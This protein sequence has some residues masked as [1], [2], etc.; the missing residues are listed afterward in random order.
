M[1]NCL[2]KID[3]NSHW[4]NPDAQAFYGVSEKASKEF[5]HV[6]TPFE[7][8]PL[9]S[10]YEQTESGINEVCRGYYTFPIK[11]KLKNKH[12]K[13]LQTITMNAQFCPFCGQNLRDGQVADYQKRI[14][15]ACGTGQHKQ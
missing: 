4:K 15:E 14:S 6:I 8:G 11:L 1:C 12:G 2:S 9:H 5:D 10:L 3:Q 7:G 13:V